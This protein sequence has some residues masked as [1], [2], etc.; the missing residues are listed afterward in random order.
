M[1]CNVK[2]LFGTNNKDAFI[3]DFRDGPSQPFFVGE[4]VERFL[5]YR[6][7]FLD[8][9]PAEFVATMDY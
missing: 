4:D 8:P 3:R 2:L 5:V 7:E 9:F 1:I 6:R